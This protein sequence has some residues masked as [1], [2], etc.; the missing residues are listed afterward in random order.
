M[1]MPS[2][3]RGEPWR[4][5]QGLEARRASTSRDA[6]LRRVSRLTG[7][8]VA[9]AI[10]LTGILSEVAANALPGHSKH[11]AATQPRPSRGSDAPAAPAPPVGGGDQSS[12]VPDQQPSD[13]QPSN[14]Q[15]AE[16]APA[17]SDASGGAVSGGS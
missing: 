11:R 2:A 6:G 13:Q 1:T 10:G 8:T 14:P 3:G 15:P 17:P 5:Q 9:I 12:P 7:W 4:D 16:Q